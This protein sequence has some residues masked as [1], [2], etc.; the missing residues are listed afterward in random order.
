MTFE[1]I[2]WNVLSEAMTK[3]LGDKSYKEIPAYDR[4]EL[5]R[6]TLRILLSEHPTAI[7]CLQEF[8]ETERKACKSIFDELNYT[9]I[10]GC[11]SNYTSNESDKKFWSETRDEMSPG[12][13]IPPSVELLGHGIQNLTENLPIQR[14]KIDWIPFKDRKGNPTGETIY[15]EFK[16]RISLIN[17]AI[18]GVNG[19][20]IAIVNTHHPCVFYMQEFQA[21]VVEAQ[22]KIASDLL[23]ESDFC[24]FTGDWNQRPQDDIW[25]D[26]MQDRRSDLLPDEFEG[27]EN[28]KV[29]TYCHPPEGFISN[30]NGGF[31]GVL[32]HIAVYSS[33]LRTYQTGEIKLLS[34]PMTESGPSEKYC[35][36]HVPMVYEITLK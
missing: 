10:L 1:I 35:S 24:I 30:W 20:K 36:D 12:M 18:I 33:T 19:K 6:K 17:W 31:N 5:M 25:Q 9:S 11:P 14:A 32:T 26:T 8:G 13:Y 21:L 22:K 34:E 23:K 29:L 2:S 27:V 7:V 4:Y 15:S 3:C 16:R 28:L